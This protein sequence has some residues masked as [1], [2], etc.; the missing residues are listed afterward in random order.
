M[1]IYTPM[2]LGDLIARLDELGDAEVYGLNGLVHS[3]ADF[4][5]RPAT[6]PC[7]WR[8]PASLLAKQYREHIGTPM[9]GWGGGTYTV[10]AD[11]V[12]YYAEMGERRSP[13]IAA[14]EPGDDGS[15]VLV[16]VYESD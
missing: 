7:N 14:L 10:D 15:Y 2:T 13:I 12:L 5:D 1:K 16:G 3:Y 8:R 11:K 9:P 6:E 4:Y